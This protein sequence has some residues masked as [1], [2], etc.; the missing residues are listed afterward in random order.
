MREPMTMIEP[1]SARWLGALDWL[2][3]RE[4][5]VIAAAV[6]L[7]LG[8]LAV[9]VVRQHA[10]LAVGQPI[11]LQVAPVDPRDL[12]RGD[13]VI[14]RYAFSSTSVRDIEGF[15]KDDPWNR[16]GLSVSQWMVD[17]PVYVVLEAGKDGTWYATKYSL[18]QPKEGVYLRGL[19]DREWVVSWSKEYSIGLRF[20]IEAYY[21][22]EGTGKEY[23][24]VRNSGRLRADVRV[25]PWGEARLTGLRIVD[26]QTPGGGG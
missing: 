15:P 5:G 24:S 10:V 23:E 19:A 4:K 9:M 11:T 13:Y 7:Q 18:H 14:L 8:I 3:G 12:F 21:L 25:A 26:P 2:K 6:V 16:V 1:A 20:G 17:R 22:Q